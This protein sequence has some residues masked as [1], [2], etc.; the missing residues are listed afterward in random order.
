MG[1]FGSLGEI[2]SGR[3]LHKNTTNN[4]VISEMWQ[5]CDT[6]PGEH[7]ELF[8]DFIVA[9]SGVAEQFFFA[10]D[11]PKEIN[12]KNYSIEQFRLFY[13]AVVSFFVYVHSV[14]N[15]KIASSL[16]SC[17]KPIVSDHARAERL[18]ARLSRHSSVDS[19]T[20][21]EVYT[22]LIEEAKFG[23]SLFEPFTVFTSVCLI[24]YQTAVTKGA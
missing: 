9:A 20:V 7:R 1:I 18:F 13:D 17:L 22:H 8:R 10:Y 21:G 6:L 14:A 11:H 4:V 3:R 15:P 16:R 5:R 23:A 12:A 2:I 24:A 19:K